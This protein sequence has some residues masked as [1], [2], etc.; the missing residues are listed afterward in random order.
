[1]QV[2][3][4]SRK[5]GSTLK[6]AEMR[7]PL[8]FT[9]S[10]FDDFLNISFSEEL[11]YSKYFFGNGDYMDDHFQY[12]NNIHKVKIFTDL[13]KNYGDF[14]HVMQPSL[15]YIKPGTENENPVSFDQLLDEQKDLF[16]VGLPEEYYLFSLSNYFYDSQAK[17]KFYQHLSQKY[18][19]NRAYKYSD[20][21]NE[22]LYNYKHWKFY[23]NL[24][25]APE[26]NKI[27]ESSSFISLQEKVYNFALG[28]T[29]KQVLDD[30]P[31]TQAANDLNL[32]FNYA[33]NERINF[34]AGVTYNIDDA[35]S[36]QWSFGGSYHRD[37]WSMS[38][39]VRQ[40]ITPRP[41]GYTKDNTFYIQFNFIPFGGI[42]T[43]SLK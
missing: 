9:T 41:T 27:R 25:Y 13:T 21:S 8:E 34:G 11:Y 23:N 4:L 26:F 22:M 19:V 39:S 37:C 16:S 31:G 42:G 1:M 6:Q 36:R 24:V 7:I 32:K 29:Y 15:E 12:Y 5:T 3:N 43:D 38:A 20:L 14:I 35:S 28:H 2:K 30:Q 40:D 18:Y 10:F 33:Y 17:L